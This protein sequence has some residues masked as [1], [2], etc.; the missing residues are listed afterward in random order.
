MNNENSSNKLSFICKELLKSTH[1]HFH[2]FE[3]STYI[4]NTN[5][6]KKK[7]LLSAFFSYG[8]PM[9]VI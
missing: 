3:V 1:F 5:T 9:E 7:T 4:K 8:L 6:I 2:S